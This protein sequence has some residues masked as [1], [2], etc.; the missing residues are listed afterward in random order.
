MQAIAIPDQEI[1]VIRTKA[2]KG[3]NAARDLQIISALDMTKA[4]DLLG[5]IKLALKGVTQKKK[6][7]TD[8]LNL[9][10]GKIRELF[11]PIET[12]LST[13]EIEV[14]QK[15][16]EYQQKVDAQA[17]EDLEKIEE[18]VSS[19]EMTFSEA[20]QSATEIQSMPTTVESK[21]GSVTF[22]E[23]QVVKI[24]DESSIPREYLVPDMVKIRK[25][26]LAGVTI[27]GVLVETEKQVAGRY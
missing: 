20:N 5:N 22:K 21:K 16:L 14:K 9:A 7:I 23:I 25:V 3:L 24:I 13:A 4:T 10:L 15:M 1:T 6:E 2:T 17:K 27:P 11:R 12:S 18:K 26:A 8:P 19:G